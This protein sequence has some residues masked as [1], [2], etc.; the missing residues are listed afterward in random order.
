MSHSQVF[1]SLIVNNFV[2]QRSDEE[3]R[4][5]AEEERLQL[6]AEEKKAWEALQ[7]AQE[8]KAELSQI[9][10]TELQEAERKT[11]EAKLQAEHE[12][13]ER[14]E[15]GERWALKAIFKRKPPETK[16]RGASP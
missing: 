5:A 14:I 2:W 7:L 15:Q 3:R 13:T 10:E 11:E 1:V 12:E 4:Q 8:R 16:S 9:L 6:E